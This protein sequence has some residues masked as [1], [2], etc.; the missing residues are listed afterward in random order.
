MNSPYIA[1]VMLS[2]IAGDSVCGKE[3]V[4]NLGGEVGK[5][6]RLGG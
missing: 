4:E 6:A 2:V 1:E 3:R 5:E